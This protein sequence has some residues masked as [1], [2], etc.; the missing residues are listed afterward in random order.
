[1]GPCLHLEVYS[2]DGPN[3]TGMGIG[4]VALWEVIGDGLDG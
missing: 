2:D 4:N 1:M 3:R